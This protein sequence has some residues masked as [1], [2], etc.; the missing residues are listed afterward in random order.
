MN[1]SIEY[2]VRHEAGR[3]L[4]ETYRGRFFCAAC[5]AAFLRDTLGTAYTKAQIERASD[6]NGVAID[7]THNFS[8]ETLGSI[9]WRC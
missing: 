5:L 1:H 7:E 9:R 8:E 6:H 3:L 4:R 2:R